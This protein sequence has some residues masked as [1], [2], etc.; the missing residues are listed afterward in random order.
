MNK[1]QEQFESKTKHCIECGKEVES[2]YE[3]FCGKFIRL[4]RCPHCSQTVDKY[5]EYDNRLPI[6]MIC[7]SK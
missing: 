7:I 5:I 1:I 4:I 3:M 6:L 2:T